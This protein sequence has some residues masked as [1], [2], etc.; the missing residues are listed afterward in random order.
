MPD[1]RLNVWASVSHSVVPLALFQTVDQPAVVA[2]N[3]GA[4]GFAFLHTST[5]LGLAYIQHR[6]R[7][8]KA[9]VADVRDTGDGADGCVGS[10]S[11]SSTRVGKSFQP[12]VKPASD[13]VVDDSSDGAVSTSRG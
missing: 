1:P 10:D 8:K 2:G 11:Y 6:R 4:A 12:E 13:I 9:A 3:Y 5:A 7:G